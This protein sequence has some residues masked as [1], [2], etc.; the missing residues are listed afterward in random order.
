MRGRALLAVD[1]SV[2]AVEYEGREDRRRDL[3]R[4]G[5]T[6]DMAVREAVGVSACAAAVWLERTLN[7]E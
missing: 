5:P 6:S 7:S 3:P 1:E 2:A 4:G